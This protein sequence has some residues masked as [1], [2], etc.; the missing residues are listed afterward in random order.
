VT[1]SAWRTGRC[2]ARW[3]LAAFAIAPFCFAQAPSKAPQ[4]LATGLAVLERFAGTWDVTVKTR[5][6][7]ASVMTHTLT[8]EWVLGHRYLLGDSG[9][10]SDGTQDLDMLTYDPQTGN[11]PLWIF[12]S[13]GTSL[14]LPRGV[15]DEASRTMTWKSL[16]TDVVSYATSCTF[17]S[18]TT[19]RC[20]VLVKNWMG[21]VLLEQEPVAIR[22]KP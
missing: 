11:Y 8:Y 19:E 10:K 13:S 2:T 5:R 7:K 14:Y 3:G 18:A 6:P 9:A 17:E 15:W 22:R 21:A 16:P 12:Q 20:S 4:N 1:S